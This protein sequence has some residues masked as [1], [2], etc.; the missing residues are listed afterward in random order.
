[1]QPMKPVRYY[2][3][4]AKRLRLAATVAG[5]LTPLAAGIALYFVFTGHRT[6]SIAAGACV[7]LL[8]FASLGLRALARRMEGR[9][10]REEFFRAR[11]VR[12]PGTGAYPATLSNPYR[13]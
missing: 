9:A 7:A 3:K 4:L 8:C 12:A 5:W 1:M 2:Q 6:G 13:R 10:I 11:E